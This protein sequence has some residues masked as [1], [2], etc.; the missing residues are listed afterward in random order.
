[1]NECLCPS[2]TADMTFYVYYYIYLFYSDGQGTP[3]DTILWS[4]VNFNV[5]PS[6]ITTGN[7]ITRNICQE[8]LNLS[9][10]TQIMLE[11]AQF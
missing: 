4:P 9:L 11:P 1:M 7:T 2:I 8:M 3:L 6:L 10:K 5:Y